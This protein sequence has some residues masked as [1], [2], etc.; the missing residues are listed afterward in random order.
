MSD[1]FFRV[2]GLSLM[3]DYFNVRQLSSTHKSELDFLCKKTIFEHFTNVFDG[4]GAKHILHECSQ[5]QSYLWITFKSD[6][7]KDLVDDY[8]TNFNHFNRKNSLIA[9]PNLYEGS[10]NVNIEICAYYLRAIEAMIESDF[11]SKIAI[12]FGISEYDENVRQF[13]LYDENR[14]LGLYKGT[15]IFKNSPIRFVN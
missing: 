3:A 5:D 7:D 1:E 10:S 15:D 12:P 14:M 11:K 13:M 4:L 6:Q 2:L 9:L 8:F